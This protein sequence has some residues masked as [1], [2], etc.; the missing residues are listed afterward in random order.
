MRYCTFNWS[1][2]RTKRVRNEHGNEMKCWN[3]TSFA[4]FCILDARV[5][6]AVIVHVF[7]YY[8]LRFVFRF[9]TKFKSR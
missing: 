8:I 5:R 4:H 3:V 1:V 9:G 2:S 6:D 7:T